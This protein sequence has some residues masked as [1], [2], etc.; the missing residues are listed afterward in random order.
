MSIELEILAWS[1]LLGLVHIL[2]AATL[3]TAQ[4][5]VLW[6]AGPRDGVSAP[7]TGLAGRLDRA[8]RNFLETYVFFA[9][10]VLAL[11]V[12]HRGDD[13]TALGA[14]IWF[15]ARVAYLPTYAAG[16]PFLRTAIWAMSLVGLLMLVF[17]LF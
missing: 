9:A 8:S 5:G 10:A 11:A 1:I 13:H 14:Q 3:S 16:I 12:L 15:W 2:L 17:A 4:R 7:L 6:N